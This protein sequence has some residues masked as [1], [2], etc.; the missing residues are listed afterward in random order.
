M[1]SMLRHLFG[2]LCAGVL[3]IVGIISLLWPARVRNFCLAN[4]RQGLASM[5][6]HDLSFLLKA[7]PGVRFFRLY[8]VMSII[9]ALVLIF[10]FLK[11]W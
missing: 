4:Y 6:Q 2:P 3:L 7:V 10:G 8:G 1:M 5:S 9:T 11:S